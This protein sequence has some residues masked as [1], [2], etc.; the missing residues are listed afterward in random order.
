MKIQNLIT[1]YENR[2]REAKNEIESGM[3]LNLESYIK[4]KIEAYEK[5]VEDLNNLLV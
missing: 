3:W 4:G 2:I 5:I 1:I